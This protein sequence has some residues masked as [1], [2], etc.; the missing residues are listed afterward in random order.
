MRFRR[1]LA[2]NYRENDAD[3][4]QE[5]MGK[6]LPLPIVTIYLLGF[7]L[8]SGYPAVLKMEQQ[9]IDL[10]TGKVISPRPY[11]PFV[12]LLNHESYIVQIPL[13]TEIAKTR[14]EGVL[15]IFNQEHRTEH[16]QILDYSGD[17][18]DP[19][20][21]KMVERLAR[22]VS[23]PQVRR[24]MD[25]EEEVD[26]AINRLL[27]E[28]EREYQAALQEKVAVIEEKDKLIAELM[29]QLSDKQE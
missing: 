7:Q 24:E 29:K 21:K 9:V 28:K 17:L 3:V 6:K 5:G 20:V 1:Y 25:A 22:A 8:A 4:W 16:P 15:M 27:D 2:D 19:L 14:L 26:R 10:L 23:D 11:E 18:S 12:E 13:L